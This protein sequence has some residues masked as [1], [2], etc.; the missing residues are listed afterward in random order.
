[1]VEVVVADVD[2]DADMDAEEVGGQIL[3][4]NGE[5]PVETGEPWT[6]TRMGLSPRTEITL[7]RSGQPD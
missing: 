7:R 6:R 4:L 2:E 3:Y 1:M 5:A